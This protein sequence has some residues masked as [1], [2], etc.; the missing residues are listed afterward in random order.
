M[1]RPTLVGNLSA[2]SARS[3]SPLHV[4]EPSG[5]RPAS[6]D[7]LSPAWFAVSLTVFVVLGFFLK[8]RILNWIYGPLFPLFFLYVI[9]ATFRRFSRLPRVIRAQRSSGAV[10]T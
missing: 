8:T 6:T 9:P 2:G 1:P 4:A 7:V 10:D 5:H 3:L